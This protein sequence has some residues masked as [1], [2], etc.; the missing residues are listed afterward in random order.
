MVLLSPLVRALVYAS[1]FVALLLVLLPARVLEW[2]EVQPPAATGPVQWLGVLLVVSGAALALWCVVTFALA[3][4]GTPAPFDPPRRLVVTGPYRFVRNPMYIGGGLALL[5]AAV[6][7]GSAALLGYAGLFVLAAHAFVRLYEEPALARQFGSEYEAYRLRVGRW[8]PGAAA[9]KPG[10]KVLKRVALVVAA[11]LLLLTG[12]VAADFA[13]R[14]GRTPPIR[15]ASGQVI[16]TSIASLERVTLGGAQQWIL[17]RGEDQ[18]RPVL[19]FLHGGP[20]MPAMYLAHAFQRE[21]ERSF[22]IVHWDRRGAGKSYAAGASGEGLTVRRTLDDTFELT[23]RLRERFGQ[24]RIYLVGH[25]WGSYLGV[26]A[27]REHP[28]YYAAYVGVGQV[29]ADDGRAEALQRQYLL[30]RGRESGDSALVRRLGRVG[31]GVTEDDLFRYG[32]ELW[33]SRS[34]WPLLSTGLRAPEYTFTDALNVKK[35]SD[36]VR[37]E[38]K[39]DVLS[40]PLDEEVLRLDVPVYFFLGRHDYTTPAPLAEAYLHALDAPLERLVWFEES[41]H[42]PFFEQPAR[43]AAAMLEVDREVG[44]FWAR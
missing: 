26:L 32:A 28:E 13:F 10:M 16:P 14:R 11:L 44:K 23:R 24:E 25:S 9:G 38:M 19:L 43:F 15:D 17:V 21:V 1:I 41:A 6:F 12:V 34:M 20:G 4:R 33:T 5:G 36:L 22:V 40:G 2:S 29:A 31:G 42:F 18:S 7:Y 3:G 39:Y 27:T 37:R 35:G 30:E 8:L